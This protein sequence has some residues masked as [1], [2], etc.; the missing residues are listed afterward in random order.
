MF[1]KIVIF[2]MACE[3]VAPG[4]AAAGSKG[5]LGTIEIHPIN[6]SQ[7]II[8]IT[9]LNAPGR[10][11]VQEFRFYESAV[12]KINP[13]WIYRHSLNEGDASVSV[14]Q[15]VQV[16]NRHKGRV[17]QIQV[18]P[19]TGE[20]KRSTFDLPETDLQPVDTKLVKKARDLPDRK[21]ETVG[22]TRVFDTPTGKV[23]LSQDFT[24][25]MIDGK[26]Q[27]VQS[28]ML[29]KKGDTTI[30]ASRIADPKEGT[31]RQLVIGIRKN[32]K[33]IASG[34]YE[35]PPHLTSDIVGYQVNT[36]G[37][38][39]SVFTSDGKELSYNI[40]AEN[41]AFDFRNLKFKL[42]EYKTYDLAL[43]KAEAKVYR[44]RGSLPEI[45]GDGPRGISINPGQH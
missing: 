41:G 24:T 33:Q 31:P 45:K 23:E 27:R 16:G 25:M 14:Y 11:A 13:K 35:L 5:R 37:T 42:A 19:A 30:E 17:Q 43:V 18:N 3:L 12:G 20:V 1:K 32:D 6:Q 39:L 26:L 36:A 9:K 21:S 38:R 29:L 2:S 28:S 34:L 40:S 10:Q 4:L 22:V 44:G 15:S 8:D 7:S